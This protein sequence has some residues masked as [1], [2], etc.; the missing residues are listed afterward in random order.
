SKTAVMFSYVT[1]LSLVFFLVS[2]LA[3]ETVKSQSPRQLNLSRKEQ[4]KLVTQIEEHPQEIYEAFNIHEDSFDSYALNFASKLLNSNAGELEDMNLELNEMNA[5]IEQ[6]ML[7]PEA[8]FSSVLNEPDDYMDLFGISQNEREDFLLNIEKERE[9]YRE[10]KISF[11]QSPQVFLTF[12]QENPG[13]ALN[14]FSSK[15]GSM[16]RAINLL[17]LPDDFESKI[18]SKYSPE[19]LAQITVYV[20]LLILTVGFL[21]L[22][23]SLLIKRGRSNLGMALG[24][25]FF[26]Y[27]L[28]S[29]SSAAKG[30]SPI[31]AIIGKISP[32][33]WM[34]TDLS[35]SGFILQ[36]W[37]IILFLGVSILAIVIGNR[38]FNRKDILV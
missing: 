14:Q 28:N 10:M 19:K 22:T 35:P 9:E 34:D 33:T 27:I 16:D 1:L 4:E 36:P 32:F 6:A 26:F 7:D 2:L 30:F 11:Y 5:L 21:V 15:E 13:L 37:R 3:M 29:L 25:V 12:F 8:F 20:F 31:L 38:I 18:F 24:V 23:L 17:D